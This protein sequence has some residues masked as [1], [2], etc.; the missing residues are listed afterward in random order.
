MDSFYIACIA[1]IL[2]WFV[3][4]IMLATSWKDKRKDVNFSKNQNT[5]LIKV[6]ARIKRC[7]INLL[8]LFMEVNKDSWR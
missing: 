7:E 8:N 4:V 2:G 1:F 3:G 5:E 6:K